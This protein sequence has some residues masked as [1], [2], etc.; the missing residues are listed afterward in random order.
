MR[1]LLVV[2][3]AVVTLAPTTAAADDRWHQP[4]EGAVVEAFRPPRSRFGAAHHGADFAPTPGTPV[5]AAGAGAVVFAGDAGGANH[6]TIKHGGELRT[7]YSFL[8]TTSVRMFQVVRAGD[9]IGTTGGPVFAHHQPGEFHFGLRVGD[10]YVDPLQLFGVVDLTDVVHLAPTLGPFGY[11]IVNERGGLLDGLRDT[12]G[13][14]LGAAGDLIDTLGD[15]AVPPFTPLW[16][17][18]N[19]ADYLFPRA[20]DIIEGA[21]PV[22]GVSLALT[23]MTTLVEVLDEHRHCDANAPP[24]DGTGGSGNR[25]LVVAG[26]DTGA[27]RD[28]PP[29]A[30]PVERLGYDPGDVAYFSYAADGR[31]VYDRADT[32]APILQSAHRLA[33]QLRA[34]A[35]AA[36]G[37][38]VDLIGH[39]QGGLV[40][41]AFLKLVYD[42]TDTRYP[43]LGKVVTFASPLEGAPLATFVSS[44]RG[45]PGVGESGIDVADAASPGPPLAAPALADMSER[46]PLIAD[47]NAAP[48]PDGVEL[49]TIA[50][51]FDWIVPAGRATTNGARAFL[52]ATEVANAHGAVLSD[53]EA[54]RGARAALEGRALPCRTAAAVLTG[55]VVPGFVETVETLAAASPFG[56][57]R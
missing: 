29:I 43:P 53:R 21:P 11:S 17:L 34:H 35:Q 18:M 41:L 28:A 37:R 19:S 7:S 8:A 10:T 32:Y 1:C 44:R 40:I 46:S 3:L 12:I 15:F 54:L 16:Y 57:P 48:L 6:V 24:A 49:T 55:A 39:S 33:E 30:L 47:L 26:I 51:V 14:A 22:R 45:I 25:A 4:V 56:D 2:A 31:P 9:I 23:T 36:P 5:R 20:I 42:P 52:V 13:G 27:G 38:A 50:S